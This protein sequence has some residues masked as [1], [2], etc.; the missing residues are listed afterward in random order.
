MFLTIPIFRQ[1]FSWLFFAVALIGITF[2]TACG[3]QTEIPASQKR[4]SVF[5]SPDV[6]QQV[7]EQ[8]NRDEWAGRIK[9]NAVQKAEPWLSFSDDDLWN[10]M[11]GPEPFRSHMVWSDG[12]CPACGKDVRMYAWIIDPF[13]HPWK[14]QCPHCQTLFPTNDFQAFYRSGLDRHGVFH[15]DS[16]D[17]A[18]LYNT[19]HP[20]PLDPLHTFGVDDGDGFVQNGNRWRF[21]GAYLLY[22]QWKKLIVEGI[23]NLSAAYVLSGDPRYAHKAAI[24]LDRV[25]DLYPLFDYRYQGL[26]YEKQDTV[27][28]NGFVSIWH[29]ACVESRLLI[30]A[31]DQIY[32]GMEQDSSL[33]SFLGQKAVQH[34]LINRKN[35]LADIR[36]NIEDRILRQMFRDTFKITSN[37]PQTDL[38]LIAAHTVLAWPKQREE[39]LQRIDGMLERATAV[40]GLSGEKGLAGY[41]ALSPRAVA[42]FLSRFSRLDDDFLSRSLQKHANLADMFRFHIDTWIDQSYYPRIGD[43][44]RL[45]EKNEQYA[46]V[47]FSRDPGAGSIWQSPFSSS[48]SLFEKLFQST[49]DTAFIQVLYRANDHSLEGLPY[50]IFTADHSAFQQRVK[51]V[52]E[53]AGTDIRVASTNKADWCV[54]LLRSSTHSLSPVAWLDYDIGGNHCHADGMNIGLFSHGL[55]VLPGFGYP[56][57]QYGGWFSK[58]AL[59]Y[60]RTAAH[61]TLVVD[62]LD[63]VAKIG[64][65]ETEPM[66]QQLNPLK[67]HVKGQTTLWGVGDQAQVIRASGTQLVQT[68]K[69]DQ[70]ERTLALIDLADSTAYLVDLFRA[71]GGRDHTKFFHGAP[72]ELTTRGLKLVETADFDTTS[73]MRNFR[74]D[75]QPQQGWSAQ[76]QLADPYGYLPAKSKVGLQI[77]DLTAGA[78]AGVADTWFA[79][80]FDRGEGE[81]STLLVQRTADTEPLSSLFIDVI[82]PFGSQPSVVSAHRLPLL[83]PDGEVYGPMNAALEIKLANGYTDLIVAMDAENP[84]GQQPDYRTRRAWVQADWRIESDAEWLWVRLNVQKQ[85]IAFAL[86]EGTHLHGL[87]LEWTNEM[88]TS[89]SEQ[90]LST[91]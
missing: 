53:A 14:V 38:T 56:P 80:G 75:P 7:Q 2:G 54:A 42:D 57:V 33:V 59:W 40:N 69:M 25:A 27:N 45:G 30:M 44:G 1:K 47:L 9:T 86:A 36:A 74:L 39:I 82:E 65:P 78:A 10:L 49:G 3:P 6:L 29:D 52:I 12:F 71:I 24:L 26:V 91:R 68:V 4:Q 11:F 41:A 31:Y 46:G 61:N 67:R 28:Q 50:D 62:R 23:H 13:A 37:F 89:F 48:F 73:E 76:W 18:L 72:G 43:D 77:I 79:Y 55:D 21:V 85:P 64:Q 17:R 70:Y 51:Q 83:T 5:F 63:Q 87:A 88:Q 35:N 19:D 58:K 34:H 15:A 32:D 84:L 90:V 81:L 16:A 66:H 60:R 20:D 8:A 22:G